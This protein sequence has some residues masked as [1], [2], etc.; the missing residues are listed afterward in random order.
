[1]TALIAVLHFESVIADLLGDTSGNLYVANELNRFAELSATTEIRMASNDAKLTGFAQGWDDE[2]DLSQPLTGALFDILVDIFQENLVMRGLIGRDVADLGR[3]VEN[4]PAYAPRVQAAFDHAYRG[5]AD[6]FRHALI[7]A[8]DYLGLTLAE[9][10]K[11]LSPDYL[12]YAELAEILLDVDRALSG[13]RFRREIVE[14]FAWRG[15]GQVAV[16]PRLTPPD[17]TS[18]AFSERTIVPADRRRLPRM[19]FRERVLLAR[20]QHATRF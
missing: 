19:A 4:H 5:Q 8:R 20:G 1:M 16:G 9:T 11:R 12:T 3:Q 10:W 14:S 17:E 15:I 7:E 6:G 2:H 18:H 13:G